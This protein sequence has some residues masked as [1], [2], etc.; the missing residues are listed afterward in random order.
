MQ[1]GTAHIDFEL[2]GVTPE[3]LAELEDAVNQ[4]VVSRT[5][6]EDLHSRPDRSRER[7]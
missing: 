7:A 6:G 3:M 1:P 2:E 4:E 5:R